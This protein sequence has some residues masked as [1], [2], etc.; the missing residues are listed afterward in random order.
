MN[1][2]KTFPARVL[3][4][5]LAWGGGHW[6]GGEFALHP[7]I[8]SWPRGRAARAGAQHPRVGGGK[9]GGPVHPDSLRVRGGDAESWGSRTRSPPGPGAGREGGGIWG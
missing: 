1:T 5:L 6:V 4:S 2:A 8:C 3:S 9:Q 7:S